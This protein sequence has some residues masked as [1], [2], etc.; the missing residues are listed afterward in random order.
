MLI[1]EPVRHIVPPRVLDVL[2]PSDLVL[3]TPLLSVNVMLFIAPLLPFQHIAPPSSLAVLA[4]ITKPLICT[5]S[6][7]MNNA[8]PSPLSLT[9]SFSP[10][11]LQFLNVE[12]SIVE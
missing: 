9:F 2:I 6:A 11:A 1:L 3:L 5:L 10:V 8:P 4:V 12:F 7:L